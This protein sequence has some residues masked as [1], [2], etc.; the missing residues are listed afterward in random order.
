MIRP[1]RPRRHRRRG[2]TGSANNAG[3]QT[4]FIP[5]LTLGIPPNAVMALM[6]GAMTIHGIVPGP[7]VMTKQPDAVLGHDRLHVDRQPDAAGHQPAAD[8]AMGAPAQGA[9]P[10]D[11]PCDH[12]C[13]A[14]SASTRSTTIPL[15][16]VS[17]RCFG[18][19]GY[20]LIK[21]D[22]EPAPLLL[23]FV[24]GRLLEEKLRQALAIS[25]GSF[26][27]FLEHPASAT[28]L[29]LTLVLT[30]IIL[31]PTIRKGRDKAFA[32]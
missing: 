28:L 6:V 17:D 18:L 15:D 23:G 7:E 13:S 26:A 25:K 3:A 29:G 12:C 5:L 22:F 4:S 10:A 11:V 31:L 9:L 16:V 20:A 30:V 1:L 8:R 27:T 14:A 24:L 19:F 21:F 2:G 32:D